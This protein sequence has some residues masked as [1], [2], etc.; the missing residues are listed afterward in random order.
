MR[1][2]GQCVHVNIPMDACTHHSK[3]VYK[4][5]SP[6]LSTH[7]QSIR[8]CSPFESNHQ[9]LLHSPC[10]SPCDLEFREKSS[11]P[12]WKP[13]AFSHQPCK[14][15]VRRQILYWSS[16]YRVHLW[17]HMGGIQRLSWNKRFLGVLLCIYK[18]VH[19]CGGYLG[20]YE[21]MVVSIH[22]FLGYMIEY[23]HMYIHMHIYICI[24]LV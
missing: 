22:V 6:W 17:L 13:I 4:L 12:L 9:L 16:T 23:I 2:S 3:V 1:C 19:T 5:A 8:Y 21:C 7:S 14:C 18:C 11:C 20:V 15:L 10:P 24:I